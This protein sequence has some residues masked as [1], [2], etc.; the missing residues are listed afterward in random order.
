LTDAEFLQLIEQGHETGGVEFKST[1]SLDNPLFTARLVRA[2]LGMANR[3]D[4][5][6]VVV[7][8][9]ENPDK[10]LNPAGVS[11]ADLPRWDYDRLAG[12]VSGFADPSVELALEQRRVGERSFLVVSVREFVEIP[13]LCKKSNSPLNDA[14]VTTR[15]GEILRQGACYV[16][17]RR[18]PETTEIPTQEDMRAL[19]AL[20]TEKGVRRFVQ[21]ASSSGLI[22]VP[23][24]SPGAP[25]STYEKETEG[26]L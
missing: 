14:G 13:I 18:K 1:G 23:P 24:R 4:G 22:S 6:L 21:L 3:R 25:A 19:I 2:I 15:E 7:G 11:R 16:R 8:V 5:G 12:V 9:S 20:A 17:S 26:L 10:T